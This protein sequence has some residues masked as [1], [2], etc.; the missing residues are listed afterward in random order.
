LMEAVGWG[1]GE[2]GWSPGRGDLVDVAF[3]LE[4]HNWRGREIVRLVLE[5]MRGSKF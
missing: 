4:E 1:F 5:D 3:G 2:L